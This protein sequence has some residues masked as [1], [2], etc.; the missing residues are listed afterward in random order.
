MIDTA[1]VVPIHKNC[2]RGTVRCE[3]GHPL[4]DGIVVRARVV[5]RRPDNTFEAKCRCKR[6]LPLPLVYTG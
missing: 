4:F 5:R 6:W 2:P 3:C 1:T